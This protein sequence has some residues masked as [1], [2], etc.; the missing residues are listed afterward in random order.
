MLDDLRRSGGSEA[1]QPTDRGVVTRL[2]ARVDDVV[3]ELVDEV[4][5]LDERLPQGVG[6]L[7]AGVRPAHRSEGRSGLTC[8]TG[9]LRCALD[10]PESIWEELSELVRRGELAKL[11]PKMGTALHIR[12]KAASGS[13]RTWMIDEEAN[14]VRVNPRGFYLRREFTAAIL[15]EHFVT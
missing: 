13:S 14:W 15:A 12:P 9:Q 2:K 3:C 10:L 8:A 4:L 6:D 11:H 1:S 7:S 5:V